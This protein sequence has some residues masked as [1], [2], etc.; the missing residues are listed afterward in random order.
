MEWIYV[1]RK[2]EREGCSG[3]RKSRGIIMKG[4]RVRGVRQ[5]NGERRTSG[6]PGHGGSIVRDEQ[7]YAWGQSMVIHCV[8]VV[9]VLLS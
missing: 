8:I 5:L 3:R 4:K 9:D 1:W 2:N 7:L 6:I